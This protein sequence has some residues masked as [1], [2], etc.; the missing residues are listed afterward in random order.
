MRMGKK[1]RKPQLRVLTE[2]EAIK[3][4]AFHGLQYE[5]TQAIKS[6]CTPTEAL[7]EWDLL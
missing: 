2:S 5:V 3:I 7:R 6:G 4:A 1:K